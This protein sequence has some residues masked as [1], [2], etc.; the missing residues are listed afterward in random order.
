MSEMLD[1]LIGNF[2][3]PVEEKV[4]GLEGCHVAFEVRLR[5]D[6]KLDV[7][8]VEMRFR[9]LYRREGLR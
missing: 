1:M 4:S 5:R 3:G 7:G 2:G 6:G 9:W 8:D